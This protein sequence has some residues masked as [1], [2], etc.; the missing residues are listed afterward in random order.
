MPGILIRWL[1]TTL[2]VVLV[3]YVVSG[4]TIEGTGA[5]LLAGAILGILNALVRP[6]LIILTLPLSIVTLGLF[7]LVI[8]ALMFQLAGAIVP[9]LHV[10]S[11]WSALFA[12]IIVSIVSWLANWIIAGGAGER[13]VVVR[14]WDTHTIDLHRGR[15]DKWR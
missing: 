8:N 2:A 13:T 15:G 7:V 10:A 14:R 11:F 9:G 6:I 4:V 1:V 3:P 5:A 12:S